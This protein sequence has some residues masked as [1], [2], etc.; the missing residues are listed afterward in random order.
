MDIQ[1][2]ALLEPGLRFRELTSKLRPLTDEFVRGRYGV[3]MHGVGLCDEFPGIYY[4][5]DF[6][7][8][9]FD[10]EFAEGMVMCVE[11]LI[12]TEGGK[13]AVKLEEQVLITADSY[14]QLTSYPMEESWL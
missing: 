6:D 5:E 9:G 11:A 1:N 7:D 8:V 2:K 4:L 10:G 3:A 14:R 12:A 13:E